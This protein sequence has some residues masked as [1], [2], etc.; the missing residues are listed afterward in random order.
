M[1]Q[2]V[3]DQQGVGGLRC[4]KHGVRDWRKAS[5]CPH[6]EIARLKAEVEQWRVSAELASEALTVCGEERYA[7]ES[8]RDRWRA[9]ALAARALLFDDGYAQYHGSASAS[10]DA[11]ELAYAS[12]RERNGEE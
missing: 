12:A 8:D 7:A 1:M 9:E 3:T 5:V 4:E 6:C 10:R 2:V 11:A